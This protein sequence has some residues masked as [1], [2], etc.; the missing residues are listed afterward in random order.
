MPYVDNPICS[1]PADE[2]AKTWRYMD[3]PRFVS[4]LDRRALFFA[5][6][7]KMADKYEGM[8]TTPTI[9]EEREMRHAIATEAFFSRITKIFIHYYSE[10]LNIPYDEG[11][12]FLTEIMNE[13][14]F[15][16]YASA[17]SSIIEAIRTDV[18]DS[19]IQNIKEMRGRVLLN[20]WYIN[21]YESVAM[22]ELYSQRRAGIAIQ[23]TFGKMKHGFALD[24]SH[25]MNIGSVKYI[26][27][28]KQ[29]IPDDD[30]IRRYLHK[31]LNYEHE[32]ELRAII[33]MG[34]DETPLNDG[35]LYVDFDPEA[36]IEKIYITPDASPWFNTLVRAITKK[37]DLRCEIV[38]SDLDKDPLT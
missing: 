7:D 23:S 34:E 28:S 33:L 24:S 9:E 5:R 36:L 35:G 1:V 11:K 19:I 29:I 20:C 31:R 6:A 15:N 22:W 13:P 18:M 17:N 26:D 21:D 38:Q 27:Y 16:P 2:N 10:Y 30:P 12:A 8:L 3:F 32:K 14:K 25:D 4:M 37:Y